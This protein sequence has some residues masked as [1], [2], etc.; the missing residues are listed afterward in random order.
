MAF[1]T[2]EDQFGEV[3]LVM[4]P[5]VWERDSRMVEQGSLLVVEGKLQH[6]ERGTSVLVDRVS[7]IGMDDTA[8]EL[9]NQNSGKQ[10]ER[11]LEN[12]L[13]DIR[14]LS[15]YRVGEAAE[16]NQVEESEQLDEF[17][18]D[19]DELWRVGFDLDDDNQAGTFS[20]EEP[21]ILEHPSQ[22]AN[23]I[24]DPIPEAEAQTPL[25]PQVPANYQPATDSVSVV[26]RR[27]LVVQIAKE[28]PPDRITRKVHQLHG[29]LGSHPGEDQFAFQ[30]FAEGRWREYV[31]PNESVQISQSLLDQ[32]NGLVEKGSFF[33]RTERFEITDE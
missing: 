7:R 25:P 29:W 10:Y 18:E 9:F 26:E 27:V 13:P 28:E 31:F 20:V 32:L 2:I 23:D 22:L 12:Y 1:V 8:G 24:P 17:E 19:E 15:R 3:D 6:Q 21:E 11:L 4:F 5:A 33:I 30:F 16:A 14:L